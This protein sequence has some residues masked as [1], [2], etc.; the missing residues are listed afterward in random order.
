MY[1]VQE[2]HGYSAAPPTIEHVEE[3]KQQLQDVRKELKNVKQKVKRRESNINKLL[4]TIKDQNLINQGQLDLLRLNF[5]ENTFILIENKLKSHNVDKHGHCYSNDVKEL[6]VTMHFYSPQAYDFLQQY[7]HLPHPSTI[8]AW[9][10][11]LNCQPGFLSEVIEH[12]KE[13]KSKDPLKKHCTLMFDAMALKKE[14][15]Y[16]PKNGN[17][18]G[19]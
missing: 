13:T 15:V 3:L 1:V 4:E 14:I 17:Y 5:W 8:C 11:S 12:L 2:E 18:A 9:S 7:L 6:A 16:D 19:L 10:A